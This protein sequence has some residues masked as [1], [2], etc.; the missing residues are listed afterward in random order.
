M[1]CPHCGM[2]I[3]QV[4]KTHYKRPFGHFLPAC[5]NDV[6]YREKYVTPDK[7]LVT[8]KNCM[9]TKRFKEGK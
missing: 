3:E 1:V 5:G 9:R 6:R 4:K 8:C 7:A 2:K